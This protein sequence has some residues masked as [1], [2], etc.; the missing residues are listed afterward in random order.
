V[1]AFLSYRLDDSL[2]FSSARVLVLRGEH[3]VL[4]V[5]DPTTSHILP[6]G[7]IEAGESAEDAARRE[8]AE[9]TG[10]TIRETQLLGVIHFHPLSETMG[11]RTFTDFWQAVFAAQADEFHPELRENDGHETGAEFVEI[12]K[13]RLLPLSA[14]ERIFLDAAIV[15]LRGVA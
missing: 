8:V 2:N 4:L 10:W 12:A 3:E 9:E 5:H 1:R 11:G 6:G 15:A 14:R 13:A 7:R